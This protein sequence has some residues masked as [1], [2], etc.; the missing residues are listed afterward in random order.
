MPETAT[1]RF[2]DYADSRLTEFRLVNPFPSQLC[3]LVNSKSH[4]KL[5]NEETI[6]FKFERIFHTHFAVIKL[7]TSILLFMR[8]LKLQERVLIWN[9]LANGTTRNAYFEIENMRNFLI[10]RDCESVM[11]IIVVR[12]GIKISQLYNMYYACRYLGNNVNANCN[13]NWDKLWY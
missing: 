3:L 11:W 8:N 7:E 13:C 9:N 2:A 12:I 10:I 5:R 4:S 1:R 6:S